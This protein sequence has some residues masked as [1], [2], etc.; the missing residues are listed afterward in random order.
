MLQTYDKAVQLATTRESALKKAA[1][2]EKTADP[3]APQ[4][5][6]QSSTSPRLV[7]KVTAVGV[8]VRTLT[9]IVANNLN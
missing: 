4:R 2:T 5:S 7:E 1:R 6:L 9:I 3:S 8:I